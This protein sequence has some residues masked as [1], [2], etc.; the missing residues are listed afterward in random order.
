VFPTPIIDNLR[1][2]HGTAWYHLYGIGRFRE[3]A[4]RRLET[5]STIGTNA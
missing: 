4:I 2:F 1:R 5:A 3:A